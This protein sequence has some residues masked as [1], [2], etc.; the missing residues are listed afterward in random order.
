MSAYGLSVGDQISPTNATA[1]ALS[2]ATIGAAAPVETGYLAS[3]EYTT[4]TSYKL[5]YS[6]NDTSQVNETTGT[7]LVS[8]WNLLTRTIGGLLNTFMV[9]ADVNPSVPVFTP[10]GT[11][12]LSLPMSLL[13]SGYTLNGS[14][15]DPATGSTSFTQ[16]FTGTQLQALTVLT[17]SDGSSYVVLPAVNFTDAAGTNFTNIPLQ[18]TLTLPYSPLGAFNSTLDIGSPA[19]AGSAQYAPSTGTYTVAGGGSDIYN[20]SDQ[21]HF[22]ST[23]EIGDST[24]TAR[25]TSVS[26]TSSW[27]KAGL[28]FRNDTTANAMFADVVA[29]PGQG[30]SFQWCATTGG[31]SS[32]TTVSGVTAPVWL[33]LTRVGNSFSGYYTTVASPIS[34]DWVQIGTSQTIAIASTA[35]AGLAVTSHN[36]GGSA[37]TATFTNVLLTSVQVDLSSSFNHGGIA[38]DGS[39]FNNGDSLDGQ[40]S[41][42]SGTLLGNSVSWAGNVYNIGAAD[43]FDN[44]FGYGQTL[45]VPSGNFSALKFLATTTGGYQGN[46]VFTVAYTDGTTQ[47]FT[48]SMSD[49][50]STS[51][52]AGESVALNMAYRNGS[53]GTNQAGAW[54]LYGYSFAINS[55]KTVESITLPNNSRL[56]FFAMDLVA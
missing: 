17:R 40:G 22:V 28:M 56:K 2:N 13:S 47:N 53:N 10:G 15:L 37:C 54:K 51:T 14:F 44:A 41:S 31:A 5:Q 42:L 52:N 7:P 45:T 16:V 20:G 1:L 8:G 30:V 24:I 32:N 49:W 27:A 38:S 48:Q 11:T 19:Q 34:T 3:R 18:L 6:L 36:T 43:T 29:T 26:N 55:A 12:P 35:T 46:Q 21:F 50:G 25:V 9:W 39:F 33:K 4:Q 23:G